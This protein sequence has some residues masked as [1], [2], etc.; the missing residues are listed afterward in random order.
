MNLLNTG[1]ISTLKVFIL[2]RKVWGPGRPKAGA[3]NFDISDFCKTTNIDVLK[4][5]R[6][7]LIFILTRTNSKL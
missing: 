1:L 3:G 5:V 4:V 7:S 6:E 2:C